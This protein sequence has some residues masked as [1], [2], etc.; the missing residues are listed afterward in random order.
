MNATMFLS[1]SECFGRSCAFCRA[2]FR[3]DY[4]HDME[5]TFEDQEREAR[6]QSGRWESHACGGKR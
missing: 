4:G 5:H 6:D 1:P 3:W 2:D